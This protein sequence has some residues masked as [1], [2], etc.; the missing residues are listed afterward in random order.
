M[1]DVGA[2]G[3]WMAVAG[4]VVVIA[5]ALLI[6]IWLVAR[7]IYAQAVRALVAAEAIRL[8]TLPIWELQTSNEVAEQLLATVR[9]IESKGGKLAGALQQHGGRPEARP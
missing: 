3:M 1:A 6:T 2:W 8:N 5:A 7:S 4:V 9:A